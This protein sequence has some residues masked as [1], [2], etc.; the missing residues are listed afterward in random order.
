MSV[1]NFLG[2]EIILI[3]AGFGSYANRRRESVIGLLAHFCAVIGG[4]LIG[5][6]HTL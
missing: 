2:I 4:T 6:G 5:W 1:A 3:S